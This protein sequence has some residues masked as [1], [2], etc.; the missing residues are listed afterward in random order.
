MIRDDIIP[1]ALEYYLGVIETDHPEDEEDED[2]QPDS[3]EDKKAK[4]PKKKEAKEPEG[5]AADVPKDAKPEDCKQ[6]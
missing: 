3:E 4:K 1:L 2:A 6:Q 5:G